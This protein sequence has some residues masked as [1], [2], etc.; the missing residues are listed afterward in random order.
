MPYNSTHDLPDSVKN[1]LPAHAQAL[2]KEA[3]NSAYE[4]YEEPSNRRGS[5]SQEEAAFKV[6]WA[7]VKH[8]YEKGDDD[9][10]HQKKK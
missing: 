6:A 7:A 3:Y 4:E 1:V 9:K 2:F 8:K 5:E 10:W